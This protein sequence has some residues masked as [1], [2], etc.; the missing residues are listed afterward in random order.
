MKK[1]LDD[2]PRPWMIK[3]ERWSESEDHKYFFVVDNDEDV[4]A[5]TRSREVAEL[6]IESLEAMYQLER[7]QEAGG[8]L[9][10]L[11]AGI[12]TRCQRINSSKHVTRA[13][14]VQNADS[15]S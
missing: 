5:S 6:L 15:F 12:Q 9:K 3:M 7:I 2:F 11:G 8:W 10:D 4:I 13:G 1:T 14:G